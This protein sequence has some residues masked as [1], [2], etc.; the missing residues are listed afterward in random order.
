MLTVTE[1][2]NADGKKGKVIV[3][4]VQINNSFSGQNYLPYAVGL[5]ES[6]V[7][8]RAED[9][10]RYNFLS[11][12]YKRMPISQICEALLN[13][14]VIGFSTYVWNA[15]ISLEVARQVKL[16]R[17][18]VMIVFGGPQVPDHAETFL[19]TYPFIDVAVHNEGEQTFLD[20]LESFPHTDPT[21]IKG[22]S[23]IDDAGHYVRTAPQPR[24]RELSSI[25]SPF[26]TGVFDR[27]MATHPKES[28]IGLWETNR[29]CPFQCTFCDWGSA[30]AAKVNQFD[31][32]RLTAEVDWF[33]DKKIEY[34]FCCDANFGILKRDVDLARYV[35]DKK[36]ET[37]YPQFLS[38]QNTKNATE[39]AYLAQSIIAEAGLNKGVAI[40]MQSIDPETLKNIKRDNISLKSFLELQSRFTRDGIETY[41]DLILGLPGETYDSFVEGVSMLMESGQHN[42]IQ[43]NNLSILPNAEMGAPE[44]QDRH[45]MRLVESQIINIHGEDPCLD[46]DVP[47]MQQLVVETATMPAADWRRTRAFCWMTALVHF[48]KLFQ[49]PLIVAHEQ[50][51]VSYRVL[52]ESFTRAE[53][54]R[55]PLISSIYDFFI[56]S[57]TVIQQGGPEYIHS[58]EWLN[59]YWPAD[60][61]VFI[62]LTAE[63]KVDDFYRECTELILEATEATA[64]AC[65]KPAVRDAARLNRSLLKDPSAVSDLVVD[66]EWNVMELYKA[67]LRGESERL[68]RTPN[69]V[70]IGRS[71][72]SWADF[73]DWCKRVVWWGN[74][75]GAYLYNGA[76]VE[77]HPAGHY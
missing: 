59:I 26:L 56:E 70:H 74:K 10:N 53:K 5:L 43:F 65:L 33:S 19:R 76:V 57:A 24:I 29:G 60:E 71:K 61:Y 46:D 12:I 69:T 50:S 63:G 3:G 14:D 52:L 51:K 30:T 6:F 22:T 55:F 72:E 49:I 21:G 35:A 2:T 64:S 41:S 67:I 17:P 25:P 1:K 11:P 23:C 73:N 42:R 68:S 28:W 37:G 44:Y 77:M 48:D 32:D 4:L 8:S 39:R 40:S 38:V 34:L 66:L 13:A 27:L 15:R 45:G 9:A 20:I 36:K 58:K 75:K 62:R 16:K 31:L 47:E 18:D 54:I 7:R